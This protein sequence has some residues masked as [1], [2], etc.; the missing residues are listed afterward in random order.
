[1]ATNC[2][3]CQYIL[4]TSGSGVDAQRAPATGGDECRN[5]LII[6]VVVVVIHRDDSANVCMHLTRDSGH[7]KLLCFNEILFETSVASSL[8]LGP[9]LVAARPWLCTYVSS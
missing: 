7:C 3:I 9:G 1:M 4:D 8:K 6:I 5:L 2:V